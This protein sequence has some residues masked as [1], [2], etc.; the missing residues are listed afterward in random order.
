MTPYCVVSPFHSSLLVMNSA[1]FVFA[2]RFFIS[3]GAVALERNSRARIGIGR[4]VEFTRTDAPSA[5]QT[6][7]RSRLSLSKPVHPA[8]QLRENR[9]AQTRE[10]HARAAASRITRQQNQDLRKPRSFTDRRRISSRIFVNEFGN[11]ENFSHFRHCTR[12]GW[13]LYALRGLLT[14]PSDGLEAQSE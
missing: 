2:R 10:I 14:R 5:S 1:G 8:K 7:I 3:H 13:S 9:C 11:A 6:V 4:E 12:V